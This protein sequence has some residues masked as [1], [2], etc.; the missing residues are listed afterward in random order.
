MWE[1]YYGYY[2]PSEIELQNEQL[3]HQLA[4]KD[5]ALELAVDY[6]FKELKLDGYQ[7]I[8]WDGN[9]LTLLQ[10]NMQVFIEQAEKELKE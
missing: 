8:H 9:D 5:K 1:E 3:K 10:E 7:D 6:M 4:V 2:E